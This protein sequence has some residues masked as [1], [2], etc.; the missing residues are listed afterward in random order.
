MVAGQLRVMSVN[1]DGIGK[2]GKRLALCDLPQTMQIR[3]CVVAGGHSRKRDPKPVRI[4][5]LEVVADCCRIAY[6]R[7][8]GC[9]VAS[10]VRNTAT[11][12]EVEIGQGGNRPVESCPI[13]V[14]PDKA[15]EM[16]TKAT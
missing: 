10:M 2:K 16:G 7:R 14:F 15:E 4:P 3:V 9:R 13:I 1:C 12:E 6:R 8:K 5:G 11:T